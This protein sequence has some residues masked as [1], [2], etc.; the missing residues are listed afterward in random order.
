LGDGEGQ[1][2]KEAELAA[3]LAQR[4]AELLAMRAQIEHMEQSTVDTSD[5][6]QN[7]K[8]LEE[9]LSRSRGALVQREQTERVVNKSLK[10]AL[11]LLRPQQMHLEE[12]EQ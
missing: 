7:I 10:E 2:T 9:D 1:P 5:S 12:A 11:G 4:E 8:A 3:S 6:I